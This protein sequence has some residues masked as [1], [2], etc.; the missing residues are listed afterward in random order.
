MAS[1]TYLKACINGARTRDQHPALPVTPTQLADAAVAARQAGAQAVHLHPKTADGVDSLIPEIVAAAV[2]AVRDAVPGLPLG[3]TTGFWA[4]SDP[5]ERLRTVAGWTVLPDF[6][7]VNWHEPGSEALARHLLSMGV[8]VEAGLFTAD[9]AIAWAASD[10][11]GRCLRVMVELGPYG[12][13]DTADAMLATVTEAG[14]PAPVL[15]H[16]M[17]ESCWAMV[18]HAGA[19]GVQTRIGLEDTV[20]MPD[21]TLA[22][23]NAELVSAAV[24]LLSR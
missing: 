14:S 6:A 8:G 19:R 2:E 22:A 24:A 13:V 21:G 11:A 12:D 9:A 3:V 10:L 7:S 1:M 16:G 5:D 17:D 23:G 20:R 15:L 4:L 18:E